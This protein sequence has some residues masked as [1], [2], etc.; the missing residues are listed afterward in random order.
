[1][2]TSLLML[3]M[4]MA[5]PLV[6]ANAQK[7][8]P[9]YRYKHA[10]IEIVQLDREV[11]FNGM[12]IGFDEGLRT[13]VYGVLKTELYE[14]SMANQSARLAKDYLYVRGRVLSFSGGET[15][16]LV[17][18]WEFLDAVSRRSLAVAKVS[19]EVSP[20][21]SYG[22]LAQK[23]ALQVWHEMKAL[24]CKYSRTGP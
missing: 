14:V 1:M 8:G 18:D 21:E 16:R 17:M 20:P 23:T 7:R 12:P 3:G 22:E 24:G 2:K 19:Q 15:L 5:S 6:S 4:L 10:S 11:A 13:A 9:L